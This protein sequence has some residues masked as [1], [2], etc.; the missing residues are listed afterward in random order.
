MKIDNYLVRK[1]VIRLILI[2]TSIF[3]ITI[4]NLSE[5]K[6]LNLNIL[7]SRNIPVKVLMTVLILVTFME[8][9]KIGLILMILFCSII[10]NK[11]IQRT[12]HFITDMN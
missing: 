4:P 5:K 7:I 11:D 3:I 1:N 12:E 6:K 2:I 10:S 9:F 8:D